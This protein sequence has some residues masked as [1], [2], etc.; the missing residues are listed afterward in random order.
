MTDRHP[1]YA[2]PEMR[3]YL[4]GL[5]ARAIA[6]DAMAVTEFEMAVDTLDR[7]ASGHENGHHPLTDRTEL[8]GGDLRDCTVSEF[9][10]GEHSGKHGT[11]RIVWR[12]LSEVPGKGAPREV[13]FGGPRQ[14]SPDLYEQTLQAAERA[15]DRSVPEL[16]GP[17]KQPSYVGHKGLPSRNSALETQKVAALARAGVVPLA[18]SVPL[19]VSAFGAR[20]AGSPVHT[21]GRGLGNQPQRE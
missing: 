7:L 15:P 11:H 17:F 5:R 3:G 10:V 4:E 12:Q 18:K 6:G 20:G 19:D 2:T 14:Q 1:L 9:S 16:D 21:A 13:I 8:G